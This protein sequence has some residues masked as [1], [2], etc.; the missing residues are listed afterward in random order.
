[1]DYTGKV[2]RPGGTSWPGLQ[3]LCRPIPERP[4]VEST[5][6]VPATT[7][8]REVES[9]AAAIESL[10]ELAFH[11]APHRDGTEQFVVNALRRAG[12]LTLSLVAED[13]GALVGH[14]AVSP[15]RISDGSQG[16]YG[17]GPVAVAPACQRRGIGA[18]LI[19][20]ALRELC[21]LGASGCVVL[22]DPAYYG[23]FGFRANPSLVLPEV[24]PEYFQ[25]VAF[26]ET[27]PAGTV[28]YH[29]A[30]GA[31]G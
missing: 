1:M 18:Q 6:V 21:A 9:D 16:W 7:I 27:M 31:T 14:V 30:F 12:A 13:G 29:A 25:V 2:R 5:P 19:E 22:G 8:R 15:V 11:D 24:P 20:R 4:W 26:L 3:N 23:R 10:V 17:L 28:E